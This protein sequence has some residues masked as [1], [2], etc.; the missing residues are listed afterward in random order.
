M[1]AREHPRAVNSTPKRIILALFGVGALIGW[2]YVL[3]ISDLFAV[4]G[5]EASG[6]K[7]L[8]RY[9]VER[10]VLTYLDTRTG[11]RPWHARHQWFVEGGALKAFLEDQLF[12]ERVDIVSIKNILRLNIVERASK[13]IFYS[14]K[15]YYWADAHGIVT[16]EMPLEERKL[17]QARILGQR[18][19][20]STDPPLIHQDLDDLI[21]VGYR[22]TDAKTMRRWIEIVSDLQ[23]AGILYREFIPP[24]G[25]STNAG[26]IS[27]DGH[28]VVFDLTSPLTPQFDTYVT[29]RESKEGRSIEAKQVD[30]RIPGKI[31]LQ[32]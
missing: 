18:Q 12:V 1:A 24:R 11:W 26:F 3:M 19:A 2:Y 13:V 27:H 4:K 21:D 29:W 16:E 8:S 15:Q 7:T 22:I 14:H 30:I 5:I 9:D 28:R 31:Y 23:R 20:Q 17:A 10:E 25:T 6:L 32:P